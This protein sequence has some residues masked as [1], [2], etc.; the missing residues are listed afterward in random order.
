MQYHP[1]FLSKPLQ[2][3]PLFAEFVRKSRE[4]GLRRAGG[5]GAP[6]AQAQQ[7]QATP[8]MKGQPAFSFSQLSNSGQPSFGQ[9]LV[10]PLKQTGQAGFGAGSGAK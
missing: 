1:E 7:M 2:P 3:H 5:V 10:T 6:R 4:H 8:D 9:Q